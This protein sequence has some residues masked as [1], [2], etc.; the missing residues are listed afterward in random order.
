MLWGVIEIRCGTDRSGRSIE[1]AIRWFNAFRSE[2]CA[3]RVSCLLNKLVIL[4]ICTYIPFA[5]FYFSSSRNH[6]TEF[7]MQESSLLILG[8]GTKLLVIFKVRRYLDWELQVMFMLCSR[9]NKHRLK[10]ALSHFC[11]MTTLSKDLCK[12]QKPFTL[13]HMECLATKKKNSSN[14]SVL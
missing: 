1:F 7:Q 8:I 4:P 2:P 6:G 14:I 3:C 13:L 5:Q 10:R 9:K 11:I 12:P